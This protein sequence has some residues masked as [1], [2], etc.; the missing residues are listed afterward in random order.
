MPPLELRGKPRCLVLMGPDI[1]GSPDSVGISEYK[2]DS[3]RTNRGEA[4][5]LS[6]KALLGECI[7]PALL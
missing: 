3:G 6:L 5:W 4:E 1:T 2:P 7:N